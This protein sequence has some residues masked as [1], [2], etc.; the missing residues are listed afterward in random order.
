MGSRYK[1]VDADMD[2]AR[3]QEDTRARRPGTSQEIPSEEIN[4]AG[5][6]FET[7]TVR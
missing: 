7:Q 5:H 4:P 6:R 1:D 2:R 3:L